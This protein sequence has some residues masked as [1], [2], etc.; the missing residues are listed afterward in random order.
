MVKVSKPPLDSRSKAKNCTI[1]GI[2]TIMGL[3][4]NRPQRACERWNG[5]QYVRFCGHECEKKGGW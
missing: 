2:P 4:S 1:C 3:R 5:K